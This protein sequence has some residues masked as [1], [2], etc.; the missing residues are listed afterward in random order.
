MLRGLRL[1]VLE[2]E[3]RMTEVEVATDHHHMEHHLSFDAL[4]EGLW[5]SLG[6]GDDGE[7]EFI[8]GAGI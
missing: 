5:D 1:K 3:E 8:A 7:E 4:P 2:L 6:E